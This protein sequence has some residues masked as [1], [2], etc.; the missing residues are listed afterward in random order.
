M[1][2]EYLEQKLARR[3]FSPLFA[4]LVHEYLIAGKNQRAKE[5]CLSG[6]EI[7][8]QYITAHFALTECYISEQN[9]NAALQSIDTAISLN[10]NIETLQTLQSEI[11]DILTSLSIPDTLNTNQLIE[12][13]ASALP[14]IEYP[15][16]EKYEPIYSEES[17][18]L[19]DVEIEKLKI[20]KEANRESG[21]EHQSV[22]TV[23]DSTVVPTI[24]TEIPI[25]STDQNE[26]IQAI[27]DIPSTQEEFIIN[28]ESKLELI[29]A[30]T[31]IDEP[32]SHNDKS[33]GKSDSQEQDVLIQTENQ[34]VSNDVY[35]EPVETK[36]DEDDGRIVSRTLAEIY[37]S[38]GEHLEAIVTYQLLKQNRP[39]LR[40]EIEKR[41]LELEG[42]IRDR[43]SPQQN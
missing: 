8:P 12:D 35:S 7:Y 23:E 21:I 11:Q 6:L 37:A 17:I 41:I 38:Q 16:V 40:E 20:P 25:E 19:H 3:P 39:D 2:I 42:N 27:T 28:D 13:N 34:I 22:P 5:L 18:A 24:E 31:E 15:P 43:L 10:P 4:R 36:M 9:Y 1:K 30:K 26:I 29:E 14:T 32:V 33:I